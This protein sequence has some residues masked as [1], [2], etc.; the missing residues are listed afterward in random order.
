VSTLD[1]GVR[2]VTERISS[3]RS[4][5]LGFWINTGSAAEHDSEAGI[6][7][8]LE[9]MLF[10]GTERYGSEE[11]DQIFDAMGAEINA[12]TDKEAT[13][14]YTRVLDGHLERAFEVSSDMI[15]NPRFGELQAEREVVLEE[16]AMYEDDPQDRVFD[17]LGRAIF[18]SHPLGRAVIGTAEVIAGVTREQ[19][20]A[21]HAGRYV[22]A[23]IVIAA[24]GSLDHD[25]LVE[26]AQRV[27]AGCFEAN[28]GSWP[29]STPANPEL[30]LAPEFSPRVSFLQKDT[31]QFHVCVGG[32]G[33]AREDE[34]R[35]ALRVLEGV[36]GGTSSSRL[37]QEVRERRGLAY[38]VFSF[39][40]LYA[41]GARRDR[42]G[43]RALRRRSGQRGG[44]DPLAREPQGQGRARA[45]VDRCA[46]EPAR[47]LAAER[48]ADPVGQRDDRADR[49]GH[50]RA[51]T[52]S[53]RRAVRATAPVGRRRRPRRA[54]FQG[55]DRAARRGGS[56]T[57]E[58][59]RSKGVIRVAVAGAAG[60]MGLA[61]CAAVQAA[62]DME[63]VGR[64]DPL[65]GVTLVE[66]LATAD[67]VVDFTVPATALENAL[68]CVRAGVHVVIG[69]TGFDPAPLAQAEPPADRPRGNVLIAPNFAIGAVLMMRFAQEAAAHMQKAEIIEL[70][71]DAK[72]D[73]PSGTAARTAEL[74]AA[75]SGG[76]R[77]PIHSVRLPGLVAHQEVILGDLGQTLSI[78]HDT[79]SR[80]S[81]MPGVLLAVRKVGGLSQPLVVGL[82]SLLF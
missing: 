4:V 61:V 82:E 63:L 37:F 42:D 60:R 23:N 5:A 38:S 27:E 71:H 19:L 49:R 33:I 53:R 59:R 24:A 28:G 80:E 74:M 32:A 45:R 48:D 7:H 11:I 70:H 10:R 47:R 43:A 18:D 1:S 64:A 35:F 9:H 26:M 66:V 2:V 68:A 75:A 16:I 51:G 20:A 44:A 40:N 21:F 15:W 36:L 58:R 77:P 30:A 50:D 79:I 41:R 17:V 57:G 56:R 76:V 78:R 13:S 34:R 6:S 31:E 8:L 62:S 67:V 54:A 14:L 69:T 25:A 81:F 29:A 39:S 22:P 12:G 65:L 72:L 73:A 55:G 52:R 46:H 3:V